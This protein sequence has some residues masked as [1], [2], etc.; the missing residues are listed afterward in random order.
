MR[1]IIPLL[2]LSLL[3]GCAAHP[4]A[5]NN[6]TDNFDVGMPGGVTQRVNNATFCSTFLGGRILRVGVDPNFKPR[7]VEWIRHAL[8][9]FRVLNITATVERTNVEVMVVR[10]Y[11]EP[12]CANGRLGEYHLGT[13]FVLIDPRCI[14]GRQQFE[15]VVEHELGHW[16]G[17]RHV[18]RPNGRTTDIC[19]EVGR[20]I[21]IMNP[22]LDFDHLLMP[23]PL[24]IAEYDRVYFNRCLK[25]R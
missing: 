17:M 4:T 3:F 6:S 14:S 1:K 25:L 12:N 18:C 8:T 24:D 22:Y 13:N 23:T 5:Y 19:S 2:F 11:N 9:F 10:W 20:G 21:G 7:E 16:L 15:A